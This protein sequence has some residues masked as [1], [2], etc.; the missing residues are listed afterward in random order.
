MRGF[1]PLVTALING[2]RKIGVT[3]ICAVKEYNEGPIL[4]Q[5]SIS[6]Q[7]PIKIS[8][9]LALIGRCYANIAHTLGGYI[10]DSNLPSAISQDHD[11]ATYSV[12][13]DEDDY[14]V[15][16]DKHSSFIKRF[17]DSVGWPYKGASSYIGNQL[18]SILDAYEVPDLRIAN[19][20]T[21]K[22]LRYK[23]GNPVVICGVGLLALTKVVDSSGADVLPLHRFRT[24]LRS[25]LSYTNL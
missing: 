2:H 10:V 5:N 13:R 16:W 20:E 7:Y 18:V 11:S 22:I 6:I 21:G 4:C 12:W 17:I 8:T 24:R 23:D 15:D 9:A 14:L 25:S 1:N 3:A 19:R